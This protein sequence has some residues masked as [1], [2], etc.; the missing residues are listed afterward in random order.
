MLHR[1]YWTNAAGTAKDVE[2]LRPVAKKAAA[3]F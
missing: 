2:A 1:Q 3:A